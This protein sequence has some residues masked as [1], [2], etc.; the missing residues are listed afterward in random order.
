MGLGEARLPVYANDRRTA[1]APVPPVRQTIATPVTDAR[2]T[3][4]TVSPEGLAY[5][6]N[7][8]KRT[9]R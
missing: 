5:R 2:P 6:L 3:S 7:P 4:E 9:S 1:P 8:S